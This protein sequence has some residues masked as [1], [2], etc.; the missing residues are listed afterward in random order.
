M[1][2]GAHRFSLKS[3]AWAA[4]L[5]LLA[6]PWHLALAAQCPKLL[7]FDGFDIRTQNNAQQAAYWGTTVGVQGF[8]VNSVMAHW[9]KDVGCFVERAIALQPGDGGIDVVLV[10]S[11][12]CEP[13][14]HLAL[15]QLTP[16]EHL[17]GNDV[18]ILVNAQCPM[19][20]AQ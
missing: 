14:A 2:G 9:Q 12:P 4:L 3:L 20:N 11:A 6:G 10:E 8:F 18:W 15:G 1:N 13:F 17:Q 5:V 16:R 7:M 19:P